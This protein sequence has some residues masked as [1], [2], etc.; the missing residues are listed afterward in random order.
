MD[1]NLIFAIV[2]VIIMSAVI[3]FNRKQIVVQKIAFPL[4]YFVMLRT[5]LGLKLMDV[6][7]KKFR[8]PLKQGAYLGFFRY[9]IYCLCV[10]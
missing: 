7:A 5:K 1:I 3:Y 9:G 2:F 8:W 4:L 6:I 10:N